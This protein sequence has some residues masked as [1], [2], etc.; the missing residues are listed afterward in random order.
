MAEILKIVQMSA[1]DWDA[2]KFEVIE[3]IIENAKRG[4]G[5]RFI[6]RETGNELEDDAGSTRP[7]SPAA[8]AAKGE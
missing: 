3:A 2:L 6:S 1:A 5:C 8:Q 7:Q 4:Y